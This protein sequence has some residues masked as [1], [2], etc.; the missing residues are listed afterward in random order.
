MGKSELMGKATPLPP[1]VIPCV[2]NGII[3]LNPV[4]TVT[5]YRGH[6]VSST[7]DYR[8]SGNAEARAQVVKYLNSGGAN[9][10]TSHLCAS[11]MRVQER[12]EN[13]FAVEQIGAEKHDV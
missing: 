7:V 1:T 10:T 3:N 8:A 2:R 5:V 11:A 12:A 4:Y 6:T 13:V 9:T